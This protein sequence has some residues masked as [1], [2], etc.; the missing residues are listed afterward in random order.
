MRGWWRPLDVS[1]EWSGGF[2]R[3]GMS[4][5]VGLAAQ[6][7]IRFALS[8][9]VGRLAG[10][11]A[12]GIFATGMAIAQVMTLLWPTTS[13]Q[14]ASR[15]I[16]R[17]RG[18]GDGGELRA[19]V[20]HLG[21][22]TF[23][24]G[25]VL[26]VLCLAA[27]ATIAVNSESFGR[28]AV[29][30][31]VGGLFVGVLCLGLAGQAFTRGVHYGVGAVGRI[32]RLDIL[33]NVLG[34]CALVAMLF[35]QV[36]GV[37]L[38]MAPAIGLVMLTLLAWPWGVDERPEPRLASELDRFVLYGSLGTV[39]SAGLIQLS[40]LVSN[41]VGGAE[42]AGHY[43][44]ASSVATPLTLVSGALSLVLYP[45]LSE[46]AGRR[47]FEEVRRQ[48]DRGFRGVALVIV[49]TVGV[50]V[51]SSPVL[52]AVLWGQGFEDTA[53]LLPLLLIAVLLNVL[54]VPCVNAI[55]A[56]ASSGVARMA[57]VSYGGLA[58]AMVVWVV[59]VPEFGVLGVAMGYLCGVS[60]I[61]G[62]AVI[63]AWRTWKMTWVGVIVRL[64]AALVV[65]L[66]V[67]LVRPL[68]DPLEIVATC[69][70]FVAIW[71]TSEYR[72]IADLR[73]ALA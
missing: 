17:A 20:G 50:G 64:S 67:A 8:W 62:Y 45:A 37:A 46:A 6:G 60:L 42:G 18:R 12:L 63:Y 59:C 1:A 32:V 29:D 54:G 2:A 25:V 39:A 21:R 52:V 24:S 28:G 56:T 23:A 38:L 44:A 40:L 27:W 34:L 13:G 14:A 36:R 5:L 55:T 4:S 41:H 53:A 3:R 16:A 43:A 72:D 57:V 71:G 51:L 73:R 58:T 22:R 48:L 65:L 31:I 15:F 7:G 33:C 61:A 26:A 69:L 10:P 70:A 19:V 49:P 68:D 35:Y 30:A 47:D 9:T 11:V 66:A